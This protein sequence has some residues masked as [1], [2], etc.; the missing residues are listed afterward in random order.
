[1]GMHG[2]KGLALAIASSAL[3]AGAA[4]AQLAVNAPLCTADG[5]PVLGDPTGLD[6]NP[7]PQP[8]AVTPVVGADAA[9]ASAGEAPS[10]KRST[11]YWGY[12]MN[13]VE[14]RLIAYR[15][16]EGNPQ[17]ADCV[18][19][20]PHIPPTS[21]GR[22]VA[23]DPLD[24]NLW[25]TRV[26]GMFVG[27]ARIHKVAPP[28]VTPGT[29]PELDSL[30]VHYPNGAPPEQRAYGALDT[31][32]ASKHIWA[33]GWD[34]VT[35]S[36]QLRNYFYLVNRNNGQILHSCWMPATDIFQG[37]D[38]L[39]Y[40]RLDGLPGSGQYLLTDNGAFTG[41]DPILVLDTVD[42]K[43]GQEITPIW[44][45]PKTQGMT[46]IDFEWM[47]LL[48]VNVYNVRNA[49]NQPFAEPHVVLGP[50]YTAYTNDIAV[51]GYRAKFG[52]DGND[53]CPYE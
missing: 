13:L 7:C 46:G 8:R 36:G 10:G 12:E 2:S 52:G 28:N 20:G 19:S 39:A 4:R 15:A 25:I 34:P 26:D 24:G 50:T 47:G 30:L 32:Q 31:D 41:T 27:D 49:G 5:Q 33:T 53:A 37:N 11:L 21:N 40:A 14:S 17:Q 44:Q 18:P 48:Y 22:G 16:V 9:V 45:F 3:I 29:C 43:N 42:C 1:M 38:S 35:V 51:C 6:V 23:F